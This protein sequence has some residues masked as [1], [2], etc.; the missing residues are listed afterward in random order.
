MKLFNSQ[1]FLI[2]IL[3]RLSIVLVSLN[4]F[5]EAQSVQEVT[6]D[7]C[8]TSE[9]WNRPSAKDQIATLRSI[10]YRH[11]PSLTYQEWTSDLILFR[12]YY[13]LS[14][15]VDIQVRAG[16]FTPPRP[17]PQKDLTR[18]NECVDKW[19]QVGGANP[20]N[21]PLIEFWL[22]KHRMKSIKWTGREYIITVEPKNSGF[23]LGYFKKQSPDIFAVKVINTKGQLLAKCESYCKFSKPK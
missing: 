4:Q 17:L 5:V 13:G 6:F 3:L 18:M 16:L 14:A 20:N 8:L 19:A 12:E 22:F 23:Q 1:K 11:K 15:S 2:A 21:N 10:P 9:N 7:I